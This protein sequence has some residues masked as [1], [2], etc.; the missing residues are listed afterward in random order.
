MQAVSQA[1]IVEKG[2]AFAST[3]LPFSH[4]NLG[5][6]GEGDGPVGHRHAGLP[7]CG[8][9]TPGFPGGPG[10]SCGGFAAG[11]QLIGPVSFAPRLSEPL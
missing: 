7:Q 1:R 2:P 5:A 10:H 3:H 6:G 8:H 4:M 11:L 9:A